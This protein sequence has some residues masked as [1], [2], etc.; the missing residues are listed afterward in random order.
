M[1]SVVTSLAVI[2]PS[3]RQVVV[4]AWLLGI[5]ACSGTPEYQRHG[6]QTMGTYYA[7]TARCPAEVE[8]AV[9][10]GLIESEL[11]AV[12]DEMSTYLP[13]SVLSRFNRSQVGDWFPVPATVAEV[14]TAAQE[15]S[16]AS[17]GAFDVTVGP[18]VNLWGFGPTAGHGIPSE[19]E[20]AAARERI[21]YQALEVRLDAPALRKAR[22]LYV[23]LS[24]IA[25]GHGVDRVV[26]R[27]QAQGC[28]DLLVDVGGEVRTVG[29]NPAGEAW[30][31]GVEVPDPGSTGGVQRVL[32]IATGALATSGDYRNFVESDGH[33]FSHTMDPRSGRPVTHRLASVTV[34]HESAMWADGYATLLSVLGPEDGWVFALEHGLAALFIVRGES[35][36]EERYTP[37]I[38]AALA[39]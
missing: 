16:R 39:D 18:L 8:P 6:G 36:F 4:C 28:A 33:R 12:N 20:I 23:D 3:L 34:L 37:G 7:V 14:V 31:I 38:E 27:L 35:G 11:A 9:I 24:A 32:R 2:P 25:K 29:V 21:G 22:D 10:A 1:R 26:Q 30:R 15:L 19:A 5:A 17:G 13:E